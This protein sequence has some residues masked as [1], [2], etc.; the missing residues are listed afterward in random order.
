MKK[1]HL[2]LSFIFFI[3]FVL[4]SQTISQ[5]DRV[6][7]IS[8]FWQEANYNFAY[9]ENLK[10]TNFDTLYKYYLSKVIAETND[11]EYYRLLQRFCAE[12]KDGHTEVFL[13]KYLQDNL[14][15]PKIKIERIQNDIYIV[16]VGTSYAKLI[17]RG[18]KILK[19][20]DIS[21][22][23]Y[24]NQNV[25][26]YLTDP[27]YIIK[28]LGA[29]SLL[30]VI[31]GS[32]LN[33]TIEK[34]NLI[35]EKI[36]IFT[37]GFPE[38]WYYAES[39]KSNYKLLEFKQLENNIGYVAI[40]SFMDPSVVKEFIE[41][42]PKLYK[43]NGLII[44]LRHN[45]GGNSSN[46]DEIIKYLTNKPYFFEVQSS[47]RKH[48]ASYKA[49]GA[50]GDSAYANWLGVGIWHNNPYIDYYYGNAWEMEQNN[51]IKNNVH[52]KKLLM[53]LVVLIGNNTASAAENFLIGLDYLKRATFIGQK[54][55][56]STG[57]PIC[58]D[59]PNGGWFRICTC[60]ST[61]PDGRKF[62][63]VGIKPDIAIE[64]DL[65]YY[66][67]ESDIILNK[68]IEYLKSQLNISRN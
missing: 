68:G 53:P 13:P 63:G 47:T 62:V 40:N 37:F 38:G 22:I 3:S 39:P 41:L 17:P 48:I 50:L 5:V 34:P 7:G 42:L 18:C 1:I 66:L 61:Y 46:G 26:P 25:Y 33:I 31:K 45:G 15:F 12:L 67:S 64:P 21:V 58:F 23:E 14:F 19:V 27:D 30:T 6:Y 60:K 10:N 55:A 11:Y 56:G 28:S 29:E 52:N 54:T 9:F 20:N 4:K 32:D 44:D 43:Q 51:K 49:T 59:L 57:M 24:L 2:L 8:K 35:Q 36:K 16:N 65:D